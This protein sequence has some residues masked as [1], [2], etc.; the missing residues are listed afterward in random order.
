[1]LTMPDTSQASSRGDGA[2]ARV[3]FLP[4]F[5]NPVIA[6][7]TVNPAPIFAE[8]N[9]E[10]LEFLGRRRSEDVALFSRL[11]SSRTPIEAMQAYQNFYAKAARDYG[12]EY[13]ALARIGSKFLGIG[14]GE[15]EA[16][17]ADETL[18]QFD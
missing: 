6:A 8:L 5:A 16:E 14:T 18:S 15:R 17:A 2:Q 13:V 1:M 9:A 10:Y 4:P 7:W 3:G 12:E 11:A